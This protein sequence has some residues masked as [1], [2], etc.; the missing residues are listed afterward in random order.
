MAEEIRKPAYRVVAVTT[1]G[2]RNFWNEIGAGWL[3]KDGRGVDVQ[4][5]GLP[6][7]G[8]MV[9]RLADDPSEQG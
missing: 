3:R 5:F 6:V 2:D 9:I 8:R 1:R 7:S 4:L